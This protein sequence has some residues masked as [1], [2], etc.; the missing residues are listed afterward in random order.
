MTMLRILLLW[1][2]DDEMERLENITLLMVMKLEEQEQMFF[3]VNG[4]GII[5]VNL[6]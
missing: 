6:T 2:D 4:K 1:R 3:R 5:V